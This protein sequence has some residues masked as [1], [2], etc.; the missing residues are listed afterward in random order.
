MLCCI[1]FQRRCFLQT[2]SK[3]L[4]WQKD[5]FIAIPAVLWWSGTKPNISPRYAC[6]SRFKMLHLFPL[7][8]I[9]TKILNFAWKRSCS[10][11]SCLAHQPHKAIFHLFYF[12]HLSTSPWGASQTNLFQSLMYQVKGLL[13]GSSFSLEF[14]QLT[15]SHSSNF[16]LNV[17]SSGHLSEPELMCGITPQGGIQLPTHPLRCKLIHWGS[18]FVD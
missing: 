15:Q 10:I 16:T 14:V 6:I 5:R 18:S 1:V 3:T 11:N 2:E 9:K 7:H 17:T 12:L 8:L 4:H 13:V